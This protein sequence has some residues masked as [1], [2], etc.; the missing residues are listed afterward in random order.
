MLYCPYCKR[1]IE[2][3]W[4]YCHFCNKPLITD[5]DQELDKKFVQSCSN[6]SFYNSE[7]IGE[8]IEYHT[9]IVFDEELEKKLNEIEEELNEK[10][11]KGE[12]IG[13]LLIEK[14]SLYFKKRDLDSSLKNL[15]FALKNFQEDQDLLKIAICHNEIG[16]LHE[17]RGFFD[18]AIFHFDEAHLILTNIGDI[19]KRV[20]V[21]NNLGNVYYLIKDW[22]Q[23]YHHYQKAL[24]LSEKHQ[25]DF[26]AIKSSSNL[27]EILFIFND[28][29]RI[30]KILQNNLA[31]FKERD[32][33]YGI[34]LTRIKYGK[35]F[36]NFGKNYYD[37][38][39]QNFMK[40]LE[41][42]DMINEKISIFLKA[43]LEW[44]CYLFLGKLNLL[45]DNDLESEDFFLK[46]LEAVRTFE[47]ADHI[48]EGIVLENIGNMYTL[49]GE[50]QKAIEYYN[51]AKE[52]YEKF[53]DHDKVAE[54]FSS[55]GK[56]NQ[57]YLQNYKESIEAYDNALR[58]YDELEDYQNSAK[59][60]ELMSDI[61]L[62]ESNKI[63]AI[64]NLERAKTYYIKLEDKLKL[65][66]INEKLKDLKS[67][68]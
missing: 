5:I 30:Q 68:N 49:R 32:D 58:I 16:L 46:S 51:F 57:D 2:R 20:Q 61:Y 10:E 63:N 55:I 15:E 26:E 1:E 33:L 45:W 38:S 19:Q 24:E 36:Y 27:V 40:V 56:I 21:L 31:F 11:R 44:E 25:L 7:P 66:L 53:G 6:T 52:I 22:N 35:L 47:V 3:D 65:Q 67:N 59:V 37:Q 23:A 43:Q 17:E 9:Q 14:A 18:Q 60:L 39:Y 50:D 64:E 54:M 12:K 34:I 48:K 42:I 29:D 4:N 13:D 41:L 8:P 28:Y 62:I